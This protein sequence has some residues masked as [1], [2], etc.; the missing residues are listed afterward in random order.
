MFLWANERR[1]VAGILIGP[2]NRK[3]GRSRAPCA[4]SFPIA[5]RTTRNLQHN[6]RGPNISI[7]CLVCF[8]IDDRKFLRR[9]QSLT[10]CGSRRCTAHLAPLHCS[11]FQ[12]PHPMPLA[13]IAVSIRLCRPWKFCGW[14]FQGAIAAS[15]RVRQKDPCGPVPC[16]GLHNFRALDLAS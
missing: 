10:V 5:H 14:K 3:A 7:T 2:S 6:P 12:V 16:H 8:L 1:K 11:R 4:S 15:D 9:A 13:A